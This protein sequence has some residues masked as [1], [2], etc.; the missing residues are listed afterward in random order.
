[1]LAGFEHHSLVEL[2]TVENKLSELSQGS[3]LKFK[4]ATVHLAFCG[5]DATSVA[6]GIG[7]Q[8]SRLFGMLHPFDDG[9]LAE[10]AK[11]QV[12]EFHE[13]I[14]K[15]ELITVRLTEVFGC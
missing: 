11:M 1:M 4:T 15:I 8:G 13:Q 10:I 7:R 6:Q 3:T 9:K 12:H 14:E 5:A 2:I